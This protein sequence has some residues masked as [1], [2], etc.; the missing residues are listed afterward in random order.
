[1]EWWRG[2]AGGDSE[3]EG[4]WLMAGVKGATHATVRVRFWRRAV[5]AIG[6]PHECWIWPGT[7]TDGY[8]YMAGEHGINRRVHRVSYELNVGPIPEGLQ[9]D[10]VK[11]R[12]CTSRACFN[13][14]HLEAVTCGENI[15]RGRSHNGS[16]AACPQGHPY[17]D[18]NTARRPDGARYCKTCNRERARRRRDG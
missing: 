7:I 13:P 4:D 6:A 17:D 10:H 1:M 2:D 18:V 16:K 8:G 5:S 3:A 11:S 14:A 9:I 15:R 12:G